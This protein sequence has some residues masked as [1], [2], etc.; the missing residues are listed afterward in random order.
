MTRAGWD[1][2]PRRA[3]S[4]AGAGQAGWAGYVTSA[5]LASS[6]SAPDE[7][8][9]SGLPGVLKWGDTEPLS[10]ETRGEARR[11]SHGAGLRPPGDRPCDM[12]ARFIPEN[13]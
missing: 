4:Q 7:T 12:Q 13:V 10:S 8:P 6:L 1:E 3:V 11:D 5:S 2:A 9:S